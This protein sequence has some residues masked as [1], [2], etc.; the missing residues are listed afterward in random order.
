[1]NYKII[2]FLILFS[3]RSANAVSNQEIGLVEVDCWFENSSS[4]PTMCYHN[5]LNERPGDKSSKIIQT[6]VVIFKSTSKGKKADPVLHL[7]GGPNQ[8]YI[9][10]EHIGWTY[11]NKVLK[12]WLKDRD[13]I[14]TEYRGLGLSEPSL[15]CTDL[16]HDSLL[17]KSHQD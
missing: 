17:A 7:Q 13:V 5:Y 2:F 4:I 16:D 15:K 14:I 10:N 3:F 6:S 8:A 9:S 11:N 1:M 12:Y